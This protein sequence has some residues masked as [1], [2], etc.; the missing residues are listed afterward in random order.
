MSNQLSPSTFYLKAF[1]NKSIIALPFHSW[2]SEPPKN[3]SV[4]S[5]LYRAPFRAFFMNIHPHPKILVE[6]VFVL[7]HRTSNM[8]TTKS[9]YYIV[10][11]E[12]LRCSVYKLFSCLYRDTPGVPFEWYRWKAKKYTFKVNWLNKLIFYRFLSY[13]I[14]KLLFYSQT[15]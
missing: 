1:E 9:L 4:I 13:N 14:R 8:G 2:T 12:F 11:W 6:L 5:I 15:L 3:T 10:L 7:V